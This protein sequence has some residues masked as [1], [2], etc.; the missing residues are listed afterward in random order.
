[1]LNSMY[2]IYR[3]TIKNAGIS[4]LP[5]YMIELKDN[6]HL[7]LPEL[8]PPSVDMYFVYAE[9]RRNSKRIQAFRDFLLDNIKSTELV[10]SSH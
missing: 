2:A 6:L 4:V 7:I 8:E 5:D 10:D 1:M 3:A 9:E